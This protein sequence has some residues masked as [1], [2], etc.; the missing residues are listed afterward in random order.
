LK[1]ERIQIKSIGPCF[2]KCDSRNW[3]GIRDEDNKTPVSVTIYEDEDFVGMTLKRQFLS[4]CQL[5]NYFTYPFR[6]FNHNTR[7]RRWMLSI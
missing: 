7:S 2:D 3:A 5:Q 6:K 4:K 1:G